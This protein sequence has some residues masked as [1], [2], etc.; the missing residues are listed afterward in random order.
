MQSLS[1]RPALPSAGSAALSAQRPSRSQRLVTR[2]QAEDASA[3]WRG[4]LLGALA[5]TSLVRELW[6][7]GLP[8]ALGGALPLVADPAMHAIQTWGERAARLPPAATTAR[9]RR[10]SARACHPL[11]QHSPASRAPWHPAAAP[12]T[13]PSLNPVLCPSPQALASGPA[14]AGEVVPTVQ[15]SLVKQ[16]QAELQRLLEE[17]GAKLPELTASPSVRSM[18]R[19]MPQRR[20]QW[21]LPQR[22]LHA[23][24]AG[25]H[26]QRWIVSSSAQAGG[27]YRALPAALLLPPPPLPAHLH[28]PAPA[29]VQAAARRATEEPRG[30]SELLGALRSQNRELQVR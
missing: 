22:L 5:A 28:A 16:Q 10:P 6:G 27:C 23:Q 7:A 30:G 18:W 17:R 25:L 1:A 15:G 12:T 4:A 21:V 9:P 26:G 8:G 29:A 24:C 3:P 14:A 2:A 20:A 11:C 19:S 13:H